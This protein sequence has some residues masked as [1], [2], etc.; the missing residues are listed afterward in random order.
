M[1]HQLRQRITA[2]LYSEVKPS[3]KTTRDDEKVMRKYSL[4]QTTVRAI[5]RSINYQD[6]RAKTAKVSHERVN[7]PAVE[8]ALEK[9]TSVSSEQKRVGRGGVIALVITVLLTASVLFWLSRR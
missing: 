3:L 6:Y 2:E 9:E 4:G 5:R 7:I 1:G 8:R